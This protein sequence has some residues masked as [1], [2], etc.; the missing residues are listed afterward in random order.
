MNHYNF[1]VDMTLSEAVDY[2]VREV[3]YEMTYMKELNPKGEMKSFVFIFE[4][5]FLRMGNRAALTVVMHNFNGYTEIDSVA[6]GSS[7]SIFFRFDWGAGDEFASYIMKM[8]ESHI[9]E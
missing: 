7:Q 2:L 6:A 4:K 3:P 8:F 1:K 5:Y 9:V